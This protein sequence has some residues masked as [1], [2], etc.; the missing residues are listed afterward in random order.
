MRRN[1]LSPLLRSVEF[2]NVLLSLFSSH[3]RKF[4]TPAFSYR[5][6][7]EP[8]LKVLDSDYPVIQ[9]LSLTALIKA[10]LDGK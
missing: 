10:S 9:E 8:L 6:G 3:L 4:S 1:L 2:S 7:I 5:T